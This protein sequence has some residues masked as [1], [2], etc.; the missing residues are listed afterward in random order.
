MKN[1]I[2]VVCHKKYSVPSIE[3]YKSIS[4]GAQRDSVSSFWTDNT[5]DNI[6][7]KNPN[8]C[9]LTAQYWI[10]KN[11]SKVYNSIGLCH[12]RRYFAKS[13]IKR[14]S[15]LD[16]STIDV[17]LKTSDI[18]LPEKW[19][20]SV[21]VYENYFKHGCGKEK[22]LIITRQVIEDIYKDY[23]PSF[24]KVLSRNCA[25]YC[26]MAIMKTND[27]NNYNEW[28]FKILGE[29]QNRVDISNYNKAEARIFGYLSE[30]LLNVWVEHNHYKVKYLPMIETELSIYKKMRKDIKNLC[31]KYV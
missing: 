28:L 19:Y 30:I 29:V 21:T 24:E 17:Y 1:L 13:K 6:A 8:Y 12:Y 9:E 20:W 10:W 26:N 4:V 31:K 27:F 18:I 3:P 25:S 16:D 5:G 2:F 11:V 22:D 7:D 14:F 23:I 15:L